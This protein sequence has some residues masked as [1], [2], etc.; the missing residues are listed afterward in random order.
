SGEGRYDICLRPKTS[1]LPGVL[2][3]LKA[4]KNCSANQLQELAQTA[5]QQIESR[6]YSTELRSH[7]IQTIFKYGVAFS[8]K[9]VEVV[10]ACDML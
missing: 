4:E 3:E 5:L 9:A 2:I 10:S 8:G 1:C 7:G 6:Q